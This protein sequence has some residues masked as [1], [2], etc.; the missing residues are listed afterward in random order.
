MQCF[1]QFAR[2]NTVPIFASAWTQSDI[3]L[4]VIVLTPSGCKLSE[5]LD[6]CNVMWRCE[7]CNNNSGTPVHW[8]E[9][10]TINNI[11]YHCVGRHTVVLSETQVTRHKRHWKHGRRNYIVV[12]LR[13]FRMYTCVVLS[14][15]LRDDFLK[16]KNV[17][18]NNWRLL[19]VCYN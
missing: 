9:A 10:Y 7:A 17:E 13:W 15:K 1:L 11:L 4:A 6:C 2:H 19:G 8:W 14:F 12:E 16:N 5:Y 18:N 3:L